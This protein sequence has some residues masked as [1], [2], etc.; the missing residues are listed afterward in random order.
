MLEERKALLR[1]ANE[2]IAA[3]VHGFYARP[4]HR[5]N[6]KLWCASTRVSAAITPATPAFG[7]RWAT[8]GGAGPRTGP[9]SRGGRLVW[10][11]PPVSSMESKND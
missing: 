5:A 11:P 9:R 6:S 2:A 8:W 1:E 7:W 3:Q 10:W 4:W